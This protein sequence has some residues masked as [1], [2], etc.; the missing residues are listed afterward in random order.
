MKPTKDGVRSGDQAAN[1]R[2]RSKT[3]PGRARECRHIN[4]C[5]GQARGS[6][7][8]AGVGQ[9]GSV[10]AEAVERRGVELYTITSSSINATKKAGKDEKLFDNSVSEPDTLSNDSNRVQ[11]TTVAVFF[12]R[13]PLAIFRVRSTETKLS[14]SLYYSVAHFNRIGTG[15]ENGAL[16]PTSTGGGAMRKR[17]RRDGTREASGGRT[18]GEA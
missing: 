11:K 8:K 5:F 13:L 2:S 15:R 4:P 1:S 18:E 3:V 12:E 7:A 10:V 9:S 14:G 17:S 6:P 16:S